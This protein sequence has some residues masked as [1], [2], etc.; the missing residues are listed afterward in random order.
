MA[1]IEQDQRTASPEAASKHED[2]IGVES[3][4]GTT[5]PPGSPARP[6]KRKREPNP[7]AEA[8]RDVARFQ[9]ADDPPPVG[10]RLKGKLA[11]RYYYTKPRCA[12]TCPCCLSPDETNVLIWIRPGLQTFLDTMS[13]YYEMHVYTM[14]TRTYADAI[15]KVIDPEGRIFGDRI[16]SRDE[17]GSTSNFAGSYR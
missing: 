13:E 5:T 2:G 9:L 6:A 8:L 14:G 3:G 17:S 12:R 15:C 10:M 4:Q 11:E 1:E 16:L 7:N